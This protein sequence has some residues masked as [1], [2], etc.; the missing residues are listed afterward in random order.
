MADLKDVLV[1]LLKAYPY[2][3]DLTHVRLTHLV[4]L[5]DWRHAI[6]EGEQITG[7]S[8]RITQFGPYVPDILDLAMQDDLL[9]TRLTV[10][11]YSSIRIYLQLRSIGFITNLSPRQCMNLDYVVANTRELAPE[12]FYRLVYS[13]YPLLIGKR[14]DALDLPATAREYNRLKARLK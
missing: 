11:H 13:T 10:H 7:L 5:A 8:W 2:P 1:Y 12:E 14:Y 6:T 9:G 3:E 4:Y